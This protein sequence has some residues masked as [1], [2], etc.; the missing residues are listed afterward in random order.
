MTPDM[1]NGLFEFI[2]GLLLLFSVCKLHKDRIIRGV[3]WL[4]VS[5]FAAWGIW[6]LYFYPSLGQWYSF[7]GGVFLVTINTFY[8]IQMFYFIELEKCD[9]TTN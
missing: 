3:S 6:N 7:W 1:I 5:F 2:G 4:P 9:A 8:V